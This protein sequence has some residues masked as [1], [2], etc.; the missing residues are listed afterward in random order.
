MQV[1]PLAILRYTNGGEFRL[2]KD[3]VGDDTVPPYAILSHI[4]GPDTAEVTFEDM[5]NGTGENKPCYEKIRF[6]GE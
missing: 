4:W 5:T 1:M 3:L 6:C 2:T